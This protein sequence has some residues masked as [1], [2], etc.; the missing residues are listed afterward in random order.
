MLPN[1]KGDVEEERRV[2]YVAV[3]LDE[4]IKGKGKE[5]GT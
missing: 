5:I 2:S 3:F 1:K 4:M